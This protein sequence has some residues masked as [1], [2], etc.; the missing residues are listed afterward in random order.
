MV[1]D[2]TCASCDFNREGSDCQRPMQLSWR[3]EYSPA[4]KSEFDRIKLQLESETVRCL[5]A[6]APVTLMTFR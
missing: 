5:G 4:N 6:A 3:G 2:A 1:D